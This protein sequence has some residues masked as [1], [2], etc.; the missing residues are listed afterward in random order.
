MFVLIAV[1]MLSYFGT[2]AQHD[3]SLIITVST[4]KV[5]YNL[6]Y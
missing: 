6:E 4:Y 3:S 2:L 1:P 5:M